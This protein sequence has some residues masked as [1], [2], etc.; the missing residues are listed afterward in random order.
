[1][2]ETTETVT[3]FIFLGSKITAEGVCSHEIKRCLLL[4]RKA[5]TNLD[6]ILIMQ[7]CYFANK[8]PSSQNYGLSSSHA[9]MLGLDHKEVWAPKNW[10]FQIV[11]LEKTVES[12]LDGKE[13]KPINPKENEP[14]IFIGRTEAEAPVLWSPD[15]KNW[16]IGKYSDAGKDWG[17]EEKGVTEDEMVGWHHWL[18]GHEFEQTL[19]DSEGQGAGVMGL[20]RVGHDWVTE[21]QRHWKE[22]EGTLGF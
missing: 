1:M 15:V 2:G 9:W 22:E 4:G 16:L 13:I 7:R 20:Q 17:Q 19:G 14:W 11:V 8:G 5:M 3:D 10:C 12:S 6:R 18:N 21:Q